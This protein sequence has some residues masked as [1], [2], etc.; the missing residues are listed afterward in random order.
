MASDI[1]IERGDGTLESVPT[2]DVNKW[3]D[4]IEKFNRLRAESPGQNSFLQALLTLVR[5]TTD[6]AI[7]ELRKALHQEA[8]ARNQAASESS[9]SSLFRSRALLNPKSQYGRQFAL[10]EKQDPLYGLYVRTAQIGTIG[11][12]PALSSPMHTNYNGLDP[13]AIRAS[14]ETYF[15]QEGIIGRKQIFDD[16]MDTVRRAAADAMLAKE[17][18]DNAGKE[19]FERATAAVEAERA[20]RASIQSS[21]Q[22]NAV[23]IS[24]WLSRNERSLASNDERRQKDFEEWRKLRTEQSDRHQE[25]TKATI[26]AWIAERTKDI[27]AAKSALKISFATE[28]AHT[29]WASTKYKR[30]RN[31]A[32][33]S[34]LVGVLYMSA[35]VSGVGYLAWL[36]LSSDKPPKGFDK[37]LLE[38]PV[39]AVA[40]LVVGTI[41]VIWLGRLIAKTY[42]AHM[43]LVEDAK[44]RATMIETYIALIRADA[45][46]AEGAEAQK[47]IFRT[48]SSGLLAGDGAPDTP[49]EILMKQL[50]KKDG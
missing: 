5:R 1:K 9:A 36:I 42:M 44:E 22:Q 45:M 25:E 47:A 16:L 48:A 38:T 32:I 20:L 43:Q 14:V 34:G 24:E 40:L 3:I 17:L 7:Q 30:H 29:Y 4:E 49:V 39:S 31:W 19:A 2:K 8:L 13:R 37:P 21:E 33:G 28:S 35:V 27:E 10:A 41:L 26:D 46:K 6:E 11:I 12:P 23:A 50:G 18:A 15:I